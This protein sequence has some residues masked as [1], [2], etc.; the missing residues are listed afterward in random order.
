MNDTPKLAAYVSAW[1]LITNGFDYQS[2]LA[3]M[4]AFFDEVVIAVN[5]SK[6][7]TLA[8]LRTLAAAPESGGKLKVIST[9][10]SY[11]DVTFDGATKNAALQACSAGFPGE[12]VY[13]QMDLDEAIPQSQRPKWTALAEQLVSMSSIQCFMLPSLDLWGSVKTIRADRSVGLKF[14]MHKGG[15]R[16]GVWKEAWLNPQHTRFDTS[17][18]DSTELVTTNGDLA[19]SMK[20]VPDHYLNPAACFMLSQYPFVVHG[21]Y[22]NYAQRVRVNKAIWKDHWELRSGHP[23]N[24]AITIDELTKVPLIPHRLSLV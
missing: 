20:I 17:K 21:G 5:T 1:D 10:F 2:S 22:L 7:D 3:N 18:S 23:E 13:I 11:T 14:R 8:A 9:D 19:L 15:L 4:V 6:D 12:W 16:R 24:V